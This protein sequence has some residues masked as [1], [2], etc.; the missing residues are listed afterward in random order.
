M[1]AHKA[2]VMIRVTGTPLAISKSFAFGKADMD[3]L[4]QD[5]RYAIRR[6]LK[7]PGFTLVAVITL[8]L[9][10]GANSAI[11][12][13]VNGVLL[14]P[15]PFKDPDRLVGIYHVSEGRRATM[16]GPNFTDVA[17]P[18]RNARRTPPRSRRIE[19]YL[20]GQGEPVRLDAAEVAAGFFDLLRHSPAAWPRL[21]RRREPAGERQGRRH[22][23]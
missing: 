1:A 4:S 21:Q 22:R 2:L 20:T 16:S 12:S 14:K 19:R 5:L 17:A 11:F 10:I 13:V 8:A 15:L 7:S 3:S 18:E 9:G 23:R 6:I